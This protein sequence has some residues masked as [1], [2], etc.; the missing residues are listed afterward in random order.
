MFSFH[1]VFTIDDFFYVF[2][3][4]FII[5]ELHTVH[6]PLT[7]LIETIVS[8]FNAQHIQM[9]LKKKNTN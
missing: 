8:V 9:I 1:D 6:G 3:F 2:M 7:A 5:T 4:F